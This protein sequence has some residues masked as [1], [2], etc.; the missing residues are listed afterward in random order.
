MDRPRE[1]LAALANI[2]PGDPFAATARDGRVKLLLAA[3][4]KEQALQEAQ[5]VAKAGSG[6]AGDWARLGDLYSELGR[7]EEAANAYSEAIA[8]SKNGSAAGAEW[9]LWLLRGSALERAGKWPEARAALREA[10]KLAP[11]QPLVLN[12]LG[13]AQLERGENAEEAM[14]LIAEASKLQP[15]SAEITDS[16]GWAHYLRGNLREAI[17]LLERAAAG[18]PADAEI[19]E[20]LGD[21]YYSAGRHFEARYAWQAALLQAEEE[22]AAR[23]RGKIA[24]GLA[25][26]L[27]KP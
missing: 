21:A 7:L 4:E 16:L 6:S 25:K 14:R 20:H 23:I 8:R 18:Q 5:S 11:E 1:A 17:P 10:H 26:A 24:S 9:T 12:Y 3:G 27:A 15:D 13:Y 2:A 22:D 19:N